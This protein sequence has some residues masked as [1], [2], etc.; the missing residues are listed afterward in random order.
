M[1]SPLGG[2]GLGDTTP[3]DGTN[4]WSHL[5]QGPARLLPRVVL[6]GRASIIRSEASRTV[7]RLSQEL[8][9]DSQFPFQP[10]DELWVR[11]DPEGKRL[12]IEKMEPPHGSKKKAR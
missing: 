7:I 3:H 5:C 8:V 11:I 1:G 12:T 9:K 10:G 2:L 4:I 6:E